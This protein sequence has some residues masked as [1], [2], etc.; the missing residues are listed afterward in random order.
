MSVP[1]PECE[2]VTPPASLLTSTGAACISTRSTP[3]CPS[4]G[5]HQTSV[6]RTARAAT[7]VFTLMSF[8]RISLSLP[9]AKRKAA[10]PVFECKLAGTFIWVVNI[11]IDRDPCVLSDSQRGTVTK[12]HFEAP[13]WPGAKLIVH[14]HRRAYDGSFTTN[15]CRTLNFVDRAYFGARG[16]K[17]SKVGLETKK[18]N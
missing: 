17:H 2:S 14:A 12:G 4:I 13:L 8:L 10:T 18:E 1:S 6:P 11:A 5:P 9:V 15:L 3:N 16:S 7:G